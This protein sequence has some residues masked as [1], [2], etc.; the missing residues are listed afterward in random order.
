MPPRASTTLNERATAGEAVDERDRPRRVD[1]LPAPAAATRLTDPARARPAIGGTR[2]ARAAQQRRGARGAARGAEFAERALHRRDDRAASA[3]DGRSAR[4]P[5]TRRGRASHSPT[6]RRRRRRLRLKPGVREREPHR[7]RP[8]AAG[9]SGHA[10]TATAALDAPTP[11]NLAVRRASPPPSRSTQRPNAAFAEDEARPRSESNGATPVGERRLGRHHREAIMRLEERLVDGVDAAGDQARRA[12][13]AQQIDGA[14]DGGEARRFLVADGHV[15]ARAAAARGPT[16]LARGVRDGA[17]EQERRRAGRAAAKQAVEE[18]AA[19]NCPPAVQV[20]STTPIDRRRLAPIDAPGV[21][22]RQLR[23]G[24]R[25][26]AGAI[27]PAQLHRRHP[28]RRVEAGDL[29]PRS[30]SG[31][32][33]CRTRRPARCRCGRRAAPRETRHAS[34]RTRRRCRCRRPPTGSLHGAVRYHC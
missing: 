21:V 34:S 7:P 32:R 15:W 16:R 14:G 17:V 29:A 12:P 24:D 33:W 5:P 2:P 8:A 22:Q 1:R 27:H 26:D 4:P 13:F 19:S 9:R 6:H 18:A 20:P 10:L 31:S 23:R 25:V 30:S 11:E 3:E 28:R